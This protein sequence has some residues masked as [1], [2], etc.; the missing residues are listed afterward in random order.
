MGKFV[1]IAFAIELP[2][3]LVFPMKVQ[4]KLLSAK[5]NFLSDWQ[6]KQGLHGSALG[7]FQPKRFSLLA[8]PSSKATG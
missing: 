4:A 1:R 6:E 7:A 5:G 8:L 2:G 3:R